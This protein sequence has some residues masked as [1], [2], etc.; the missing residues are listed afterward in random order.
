M[1]CYQGIKEKF[2]NSN[3]RFRYFYFRLDRLIRLKYG[4]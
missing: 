4:L 2:T 3:R 1:I